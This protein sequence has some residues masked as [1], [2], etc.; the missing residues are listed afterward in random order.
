ML[1]KLILYLQ[2]LCHN[3]QL[4]LRSYDALVASLETCRHHPSQLEDL[5]AGN[6]AIPVLSAPAEL[7]TELA[8]FAPNAHLTLYK[9]LNAVNAFRLRLRMMAVLADACSSMLSALRILSD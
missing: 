6:S 9:M 5:L 2:S 8:R 7:T 1:W 3:L 4:E